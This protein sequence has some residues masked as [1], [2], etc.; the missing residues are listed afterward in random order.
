[1]AKVNGLAYDEA[2]TGPAVVFVHA[3]V[4]DDVGTP[5]PRSSQQISDVLTRVCGT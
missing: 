1:M 5:V 4:G 3:G 2:G